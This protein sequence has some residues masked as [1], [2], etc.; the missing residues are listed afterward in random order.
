MPILER[1]GKV[2]VKDSGQ[3]AQDCDPDCCGPVVCGFYGR[4]IPCGT[5][6]P[7]EA[8]SLPPGKGA[9]YVCD[10]LL[11]TATS[12]ATP[13]Q[14]WP[15][16]AP[17]PIVIRHMGRCWQFVPPFVTPDQIPPGADVLDL[18][19]TVECIGQSCAD[20]PCGEPLGYAEA[21]PCDPN[22]NGTPVR[23][24]PSGLPFE[25]SVL[26]PSL[27]FP[28]S[29]NGCFRFMRS[30]PTQQYPPNTPVLIFNPS[31][32]W[33]L[34][35]CCRC[36][37]T[38][39]ETIPAEYCADV[40]PNGFPGGCCPTE[41]AI[42]AGVAIVQATLVQ[43]Q[44]PTG[45]NRVTTSTYAGIGP[46]NDFTITITIV[47]V[48]DGVPEAPIVQVFEHCRMNF[49]PVQRPV[50]FDG[51]PFFVSPAGLPLPPDRFRCIHF[52]SY[53]RYTVG[54]SWTNSDAGGDVVLMDIDLRVIAADRPECRNGCGGVPLPAMAPPTAPRDPAV[55][56]WMQK[57][58]GGCSGCGHPEVPL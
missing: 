42:N 19:H 5:P 54:I 41:A 27:Y 53:D 49:C 8:C 31:Y 17:R 6:S 48:Q 30:A 22:Y 24:C 25:C 18:G 13:G 32:P 51:T 14:P 57:H 45:Y 40:Y 35:D 29:P 36:N 34:Q 1:D 26:R 47:A 56:A 11:C 9:L 21:L 23:F 37:C 58:L 10:Q 46:P 16:P 39:P 12:P 4:F 15:T 50:A 55:S 44:R 3:I 7:D 33:P 38:T 28:G 52:R 43:D 2:V 20:S